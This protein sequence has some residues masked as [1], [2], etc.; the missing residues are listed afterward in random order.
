MKKINK[1][2]MQDATRY[3]EAN[4]FLSDIGDRFYTDPAYAKA[5]DA[6]YTKIQQN[7]T[8]VLVAEKLGTPL[9]VKVRR[10]AI[11]VAAVVILHETGYDTI[12]WNKLKAYG[13]KARAKA[14]EVKDENPDVVIKAATETVYEGHVGE[15]YKDNIRAEG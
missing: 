7:Q 2:A 5:F 14:Q 9:A 4:K 13:R 8:A 1:I 6:A 3:I 15:T 11:L 10:G 12:I